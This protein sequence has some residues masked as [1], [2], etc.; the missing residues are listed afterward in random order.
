VSKVFSG[1]DSRTGG[2][3]IRLP[4]HAEI[5]LRLLGRKYDEQEDYI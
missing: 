2:E 3:N 5:C 1:D 4:G